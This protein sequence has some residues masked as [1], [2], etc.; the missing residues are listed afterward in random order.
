ML[1]LYFL[2][3]RGGSSC[4]QTTTNSNC[5]TVPIIQ[6]LYRHLKSP[7]VLIF[8]CKSGRNSTHLKKLHNISCH[9]FSNKTP[10]KLIFYVSL[11]SQAAGKCLEFSEFDIEISHPKLFSNSAR[12]T[13]F[14][15]GNCTTQNIQS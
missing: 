4:M 5:S 14:S 2:C 7:K 11:L 10:F 12:Q 15:S 1:L 6:D 3:C 8:R 9:D 13:A